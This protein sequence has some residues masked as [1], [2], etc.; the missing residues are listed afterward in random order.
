MTELLCQC[1][2]REAIRRGRLF[3]NRAH[4]IAWLR[5]PRNAGQVA[6]LIQ[7]GHATRA[8]AAR[9]QSDA[10]FK[11]KAQAWS[12]GHRQGR[13]S[14]RGWWKARYQRLE[15]KLREAGL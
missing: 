15:Q 11:T 3:T 7:K 1:G 13:K 12:A 8:A 2:C 6:A 10:R 14:E 4:Y 9:R 5:D